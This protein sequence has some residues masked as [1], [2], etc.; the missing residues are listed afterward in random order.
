VVGAQLRLG[1]DPDKTA[2]NTITRQI[3]E[4]GVAHHELATVS[5]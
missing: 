1:W 2:F 4:Y 5:L 3:G